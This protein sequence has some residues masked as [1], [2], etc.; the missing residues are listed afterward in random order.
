MSTTKPDMLSG[1]DPIIAASLRPFLNAGY[2]AESA[3]LQVQSQLKPYTVT[4]GKRLSFTAMAKSSTE[5]FMQHMDLA[6][7]GEK[8]TVLAADLKLASGF[9]GEQPF[10]VKP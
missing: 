7:V 1:V 5:C 9:A 6:E 8:V 10:E 4:V 3:S 2:F